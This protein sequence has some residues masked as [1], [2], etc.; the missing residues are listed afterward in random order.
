MGSSLAEREDKRNG[1]STTTSPPRALQVIHGT[2]RNVTKYNRLERTNVNSH[3]KRCGAR[4]D[5]YLSTLKCFLSLLAKLRGKLGGVFFTSQFD[6]LSVHEPR[7]KHV[8]GVVGLRE[9]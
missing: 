5:V 8:L 3:L 9:I 7:S 1:I 4:E 6:A 2:W